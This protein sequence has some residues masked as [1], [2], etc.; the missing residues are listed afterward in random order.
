MCGYLI[1]CEYFNNLNGNIDMA[2][3]SIMA[4]YVH[5]IPN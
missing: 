5:P 3:V 2:E 4:G 1:N